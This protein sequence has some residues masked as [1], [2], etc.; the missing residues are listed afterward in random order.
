MPLSQAKVKK[1]HMSN[2]S[3][4]TN[5]KIIIDG[6]R[7]ALTKNKWCKQKHHSDSCFISISLLL[8]HIN[9]NHN[10]HW[11]RNQIHNTIIIIDDLNRILP[12]IFF[13]SLHSIDH[14]KLLLNNITFNL[15]ENG[16]IIAGLL[17]QIWHY[18]CWFKSC[19]R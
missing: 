12:S 13:G 14:W 16:P 1:M 5:L 11:K 6:L 8:S 4:F 17:M 19:F 7:F 15:H 18:Y 2:I 9:Q 3:S 10:N